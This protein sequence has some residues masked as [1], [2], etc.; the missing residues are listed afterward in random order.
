MLPAESWDMIR[1]RQRRATLIRARAKMIDKRERVYQAFG[2]FLADFVRDLNHLSEAGWAVL[3]EG[4]RDARAMRRLGFRGPMVTVGALGRSGIGA[5]ADAKKV[6]IMTDLDR[7]G[8][9]L[10][11]RFVKTLNHEGVKTSLS[12]RRR[13]KAASRGVFLH[14]ENLSRFGE[15]PE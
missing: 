5:L 14:I 12:E 3:I 2:A 13:L 4:S 1:A 11:A 7:E 8:A 6:V 15:Q 9:T 10:A